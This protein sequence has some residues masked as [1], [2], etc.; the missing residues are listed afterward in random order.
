[1]TDLD[2]V[3]FTFAPGLVLGVAVLVF[4]LHLAFARRNR[5]R[6]LA[7]RPAE[8]PSTTDLSQLGIDMDEMY[9]AATDDAIDAARRAALRARLAE[10]RGEVAVY[11]LP[12][13]GQFVTLA[14]SWSAP[15]TT[16]REAHAPLFGRPRPRQTAIKR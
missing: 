11:R 16:V 15:V 13:T 1:M 4:G 12:R 7:E 3:A 9:L 8:P 14:T 10:N 2:W 5:A 6:R